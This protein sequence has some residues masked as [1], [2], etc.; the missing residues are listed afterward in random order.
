MRFKKDYSTITLIGLLTFVIPTPLISGDEKD[1]ARFA[2]YSVIAGKLQK[3]ALEKLNDYLATISAKDRKAVLDYLRQ[4]F[5]IELSDDQT[6]NDRGA[7]ALSSINKLPLPKPKAYE[8]FQQTPEIVDIAQTLQRIEPLILTD[9]T[10]YD[11]CAASCNKEIAKNLARTQRLFEER[12]E[13]LNTI[14]ATYKRKK[15]NH[16]KGMPSIPRE[17]NELF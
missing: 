1:V 10:P 3:R 2:Y 5:T 16:R 8:T 11:I 15:R 12:Q 17:S 7:A 9:I 13:L 6:L 14:I 4:P